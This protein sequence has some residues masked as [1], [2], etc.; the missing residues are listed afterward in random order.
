VGY[1]SAIVRRL[2]LLA[3]PIAIAACGSEPRENEL[4]PPTPV[5][6]T[7]A[8][9]KDRIQI[10]PDSVGAGTV[11]LVVSNQSKAP[12]TVTFE[13]DELGGDTAGTTASSPEI[14]PGS[15]GRLTIAT[16]E[17][18]YKVHTQD[19]AI[20]ATE[21]EIGPPRETAQDDVLLP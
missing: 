15:T 13:T 12:Q 9:H 17:G 19:G 6:L 21:V 18:T 7:G 1:R 11:V 14:A 3:L 20:K 16:R 10:S 8:I 4:R 5:T 2:V